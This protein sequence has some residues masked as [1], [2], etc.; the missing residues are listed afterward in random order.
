MSARGRPEMSRAALLRRIKPR[1]LLWHSSYAV[2][3][4][5][6]SGALSTRSFPK[7]LPE[8]QGDRVGG[9]RPVR[10]ALFSAADRAYFRDHAMPLICSVDRFA[11]NTHV[12]LHLYDP[13]SDVDEALAALRTRAPHTLLTSTWER[14][15]GRHGRQFRR[16]Y[17]AAMRFVRLYQ[18]LPQAEEVVMLDIDS[19]LHGSLDAVFATVSGNDVG[20]YQRPDQGDSR[21]K[22]AA[23][24]FYCRNSPAGRMFMEDLALK[25]SWHM[26][27]RF[28][29]ARWYL[30][31]RCLFD[32]YETY[33]RQERPLKVGS[34]SKR[35]ADWEF[36]DDSVIWAGRA[37]TKHEDARYL[38]WAGRMTAWPAEQTASPEP[39][40]DAAR[41]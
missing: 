37:E 1:A 41:H 8:V 40:G 10:R 36:S 30:D 23:G 2:A 14:L 27:G 19:L 21:R 22:M 3:E 16:A 31:Q 17:F 9:P 12:H 11:P 13:A 35:F 28:G 38:E 29:C 32:V 24:I 7:S 5:L 25:I 20:L 33:R 26:L 18:F 15:P 34:F 39:E 4:R 6:L